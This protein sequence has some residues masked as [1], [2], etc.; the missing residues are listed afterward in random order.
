MNI[1][2]IVFAGSGSRI[3]S[4]TPKQFIKV[5][6]RDIVCYTI[7]AFEKHPLIDEIILVTAIDFLCYVGELVSKEKYKKVKN[8][9]P[10]GFSR[11]KSVKNG[12]DLSNYKD[13][14]IVLIHDGDRP[15]VNEEIITNCINE[16]KEADGVAPIINH[17]EA[18]KDISN[19]GR[20]IEIE[21]KRFDIQTP[22]CFRYGLIKSAHELHKDD[23]V[24][25]DISLIEKDYKVKYVDGD[26]LNFKITKDIDLEYF[27]RII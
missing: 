16:L 10:G 14:D 13:S 15:L 25:D 4:S 21:G 5:K 11:Q 17:D 1:A 3:S 26:P 22:Q 9:F 6:N 19:S 2:L 7:D 12:L 24:T 20:Y 27:K 23:V 18:I 8:I